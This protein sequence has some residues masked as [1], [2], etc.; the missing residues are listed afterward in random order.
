MSFRRRALVALVA[1]SA[2]ASAC[3][4]AVDVSESS[5]PKVVSP[6]WVQDGYR[7]ARKASAKPVQRADLPDVPVTVPTE[8]GYQLPPE[9]EFTAALGSLGLDPTSASCIYNGIVGTPLAETVGRLLTTA[10]NPLAAATDPTAASAAAVDEG[11]Q[12]QLLVALAPCLDTNMLLTVLA[13]VSGGGSGAAGSLNALLASAVSSATAG[14]LPNVDPAALARTAGV[15]LTPQQIQALAAA[16][17]AAQAANAVDTSTIDFSKIDVTKLSKEQIVTLLAA[18][19]KGLTPE[20][21]AQLNALAAVDIKQLN[22]NIDPA[23]LSN[24]QA[25]ALFVLLLPFISAGVAPP[26]N[27]PPTG[28]SPGQ[29][30]IPPG[31]DLSAINP[32]NFVTRDN[33]IQGLGD[34]YGIPP[35]QAGCLYDRLRLIDPRL[36]GEAYLGRSE[37]G[38]AQLALA[39]VTC[40]VAP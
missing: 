6:G 3:S 34:Q 18:L 7:L 13:A 23:S 11:T 5:E 15:N 33:L 29:I 10:T 4:R 17:A 40:V 39:F 27:Q 19:L 24:Q 1:V 30:Y 38:A 20:Q 21:A 37:Q 28:G 14:A 36:I 8:V 16:V 31:T 25:G 12:R 35:K 26:A 9:P 2:L 22:L 32:L